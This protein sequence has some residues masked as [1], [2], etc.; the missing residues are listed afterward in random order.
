MPA[1][2]GVRLALRVLHSGCRNK[3]CFPVIVK[4]Q[5]AI[6]RNDVIEVQIF[7]V[8]N[9]TAVLASIF[10]AFKNVVARE[11]HFLFWHP[12]IHQQQDD[13]WDADAEGNGVDGS[14]VRRGIGQGAPL[15]KIKSAKRAVRVVHDDLRLALKKQRQGAAGGA[16]VDRL[17]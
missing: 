11:F 16:D 13:A 3:Q 7:A 14:L 8:K 17:P 10:V 4:Q 12:V 9:F 15:G 2:C 5:A 1:S 6:A